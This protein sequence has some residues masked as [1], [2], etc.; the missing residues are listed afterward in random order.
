[1]R[2]ERVTAVTNAGSFSS[3]LGGN[4]EITALERDRDYPLV[5][6]TKRVFFIRSGLLRYILAKYKVTF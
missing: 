6:F 1:M 5:S 3:I 4:R 2:I